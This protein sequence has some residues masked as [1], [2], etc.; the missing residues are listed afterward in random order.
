MTEFYYHEDTGEVRSFC[1]NI[2]EAYYIPSSFD[3]ELQLKNDVIN[4]I[5]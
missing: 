2:S 4:D 1:R 3:V 5:P